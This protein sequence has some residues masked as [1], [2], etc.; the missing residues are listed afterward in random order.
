MT[1]KSLLV[2]DDSPQALKITSEALSDSYDVKL[3]NTPAK[4]LEIVNATQKPSLILLDVGLPEMDGFEVCRRIKANPATKHIPVVFL[5]ACNDDKDE[6][7]AFSVG[8]ADFLKK[9]ITPA[10]LKAR[11]RARLGE[12]QVPEP[13]PQDVEKEAK[14]RIYEQL[15]EFIR[16]QGLEQN[17][18]DG[19]SRLHVIN[20]DP[21]KVAF[22][23]RWQQVAKKVVFIVDT[24]ISSSIVH[25]EAYRYFGEN[26][27]AVI[28]PTLTP[29]EG[30]VRA[31][32][33]A[34]SICRKLLGDEFDSGRYGNDLADKI[35]IFDLDEDMEAMRQRAEESK[36]WADLVK[37]QILDSISVEYH[38]VWNPETQNVE[39]YRVSFRREYFGSTIYGKHVL[40]G[41]SSDP[42]WPE[43]Y[44]LMINDVLS[45]VEKI[46]GRVP[47]F[48]LTL[49]VNSLT[50]KVFFQRIESTLR[51]STLRRSLRIELVGV[52]DNI[53]TNLLR[54]TI[55]MA[56][57]FCSSILV[58]IAP[59]GQIVHDL[60]LLGVDT[61]G[62][63][64]SDLLHSGLG[65][66]AAYVIA[67][68]FSKKCNT[69]DLKYYAWDIDGISDFQ[70]MTA[71]G[72]GVLSGRVLG[73]PT[74]SPSAVKLLPR[75]TIK[76]SSL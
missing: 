74:E 63:N 26:V 66:R 53:S 73:L 76:N 40:H 23:L 72:F 46:E 52:D 29:A 19:S 5:T 20:L 13:Q 43:L 54:A 18:S 15:K 64:F 75:T 11:V 60:K 12:I 31:R 48:I 69:L 6:E 35:L 41:G 68:H 30:K 57:N 14:A 50:S 67:S 61:I 58:R 9:P 10:L 32:A 8:A 17:L 33:L 70:L 4:A 3:A 44:L 36:R 62:L 2:V 45:K 49:H 65:C 37:K 7:K 59:D 25:G 71:A 34:E 22:A 56:G 39:G 47:Y 1:K 38:P 21:I 55:M 27:F 28:Y 42:L 51:N 16:S 24:M